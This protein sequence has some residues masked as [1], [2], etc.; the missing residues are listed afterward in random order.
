MYWD[1]F[2]DLPSKT[3][4]KA[5]ILYGL[6][7]PFSR[8]DKTF[9]RPKRIEQRFWTEVRDDLKLVWNKPLKEQDLSSAEKNSIGKKLELCASHAVELLK[10]ADRFGVSDPKNPAFDCCFGV[11][12]T[13]WLRFLD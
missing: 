6:T 10:Q 8:Y 12:K 11:S 3:A 7:R 9:K 5:W 13:I 2:Q 4:Q 1:G